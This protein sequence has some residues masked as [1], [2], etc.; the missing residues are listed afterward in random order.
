MEIIP[1]QKGFYI[2]FER[3]PMFYIRKTKVKIRIFTKIVKS[4]SPIQPRPTEKK[5]ESFKKPNF[6]TKKAKIP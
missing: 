4:A 5:R 2:S 1:G 3:Q 6:L